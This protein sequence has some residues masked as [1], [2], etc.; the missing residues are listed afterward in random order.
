MRILPF[1]AAFVVAC[2]TDPSAVGD[3]WQS[4]DDVNEQNSNTVDPD[5]IGLEASPARLS[6]ESACAI[7]VDI[8]REGLTGRPAFDA[9]LDRMAQSS[10]DLAALSAIRSAADQPAAERYVQLQS[11]ARDHELPGFSCPNLQMVL[12]ERQ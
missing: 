5:A 6:F 2:S 3:S 10:G 12:E 1:I 7:A 8:T 4:V 9:L 11:A